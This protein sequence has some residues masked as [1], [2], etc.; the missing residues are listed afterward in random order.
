MKTYQLKNSRF[1]FCNFDIIVFIRVNTYKFCS[2]NTYSVVFF[3]KSEYLNT[4]CFPGRTYT[5]FINDI[6]FIFYVYL[7]HNVLKCHFST[8]CLEKYLQFMRK[9]FDELLNIKKGSKLTV[10]SVRIAHEPNHLQPQLYSKLA[11]A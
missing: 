2:G 4:V 7:R 10:Y 9:L 1:S 8:R 3:N 5:C 11:I 6:F